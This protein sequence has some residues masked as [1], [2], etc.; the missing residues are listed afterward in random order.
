MFNLTAGDI[1]L[2]LEIPAHLCRLNA[3][4]GSQSHKYR[5][6][7]VCI[8]IAIMA[9]STSDSCLIPLSVNVLCTAEN[10]DIP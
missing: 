10:D 5:H 3:P 9:I 6:R 1:P 7:S 4:N 8:N 2:S